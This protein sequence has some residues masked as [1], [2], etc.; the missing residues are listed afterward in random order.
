MK[1]Y[2][3]GLLAKANIVVGPMKIKRNSIPKGTKFGE[4]EVL[5]CLGVNYLRNAVYECKCNCGTICTAARNRLITKAKQSCGCL[6]KKH[7]DTVKPD[8]TGKTWEH[9][10]ADEKSLNEVYHRYKENARYRCL[11]FN[12]NLELFKNLISQNCYYCDSLP[13]NNAKRKHYYDFKYSGLDRI[14]NNIGYLESNIIP[15]CKN[16]NYFKGKL[17]KQE[18]LEHIEKISQWQKEKKK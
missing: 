13:S 11:E 17:G 18:F 16:C 6:N 2:K 7:L 5:E 3:R 8:L 15:C 4:L 10:S 9:K 1:T 12:I 14:D